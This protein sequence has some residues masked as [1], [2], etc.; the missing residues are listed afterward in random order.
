[1]IRANLVSVPGW[2]FKTGYYL[3]GLISEDQ[4][5]YKELNDAMKSCK[6]YGSCGGVTHDTKRKVFELRNGRDFV[7]SISGERSWRRKS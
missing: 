7:K 1:M 6:K 4:T 2:E 5:S 3:A